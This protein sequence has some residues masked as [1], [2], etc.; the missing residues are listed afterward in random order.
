MKNILE[1]YLD[2]IEV[3]YTRFFAEKLYNEHPHRHNMYGLKKMLDVYGVKTVGISV[4][5]KEI[6]MLNFPCILHI[7]G[8][9]AIGLD[10]SKDKI[11]YK[12]QGKITETTHEIFQKAWTGYALVVVETTEAIEPELKKHK[13]EELISKVKL[14]S[15]PI[16]LTLALIVGVVDNT[17]NKELSFCYLLELS[18]SIAGILVCVML[19]QK[20][21]FNK[22][23]YGDRLCS[24]FHHADCNSVLDGPKAKIYGFSWSEIGLGY[25]IANT[26]FVGLNQSY[27]LYVSVINWIAMLF[28]V[29]SIYYQWKSVHSWCVLC[30]SVQVIIWLLGVQ[31][32]W[33][34]LSGAEHLMFSF[35]TAT[36][37]GIM[38]VVSMLAV[39][40]YT[41]NYSDQNDRIYAIQRYK[42]IK[43]DPTVANALIKKQVHYE[44]S[45][46][47]SKI[48]FGNRDA[49]ILISILSNPHCNPCA[50]M[51]ERV[52]RLLETYGD[53]ICVQYIFS[54]FN[55]RLDDSC[56]YLISCYNP[57]K[58]QKSME[59]F[60]KWFSS[61]KND[62]EPIIA[63]YSANIHNDEVEA[64][65]NKHKEWRK[66]TKLATTPT[67]L[68][69]GYKL[70]EEYEIE[71]L[72]MIIDADF[73]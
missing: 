40:N 32:A 57:N 39:H 3:P 61:E 16:L 34:Y 22:S 30:I 72:T 52:D 41:A 24:L 11:T 36:F 33:Y 49:Q 13:Q 55:E 12:I 68:V 64:E 20:Q 71:D 21:L 25:F 4:D 29:W 43:A 67:I 45:L 60:S 62:Y 44:T 5:S 42:A 1:Q 65:W 28:G 53:E 66:N 27:F 69:N 2:E 58:P 8:D 35:S 31:S 51:H 56:R 23:K 47:N 19:M 17:I 50:R 70:P 7:H 14:Y 10:K 48:L 54:S 18:L 26:L 37:V 6:S 9:F 63:K 73:G 46:D 15:I 38:Y 59:K